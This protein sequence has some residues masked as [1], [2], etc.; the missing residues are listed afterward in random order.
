MVY[1]CLVG[2]TGHSCLSFRYILYD[3]S[4]SYMQPMYEVSVSMYSSS[5]VSVD[6]PHLNPPYGMY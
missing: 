3:V 1:Y 6:S 5:P 2:M 4:S